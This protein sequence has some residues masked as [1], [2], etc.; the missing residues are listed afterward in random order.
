[1]HAPS[2]EDTIQLNNL[3]RSSYS[4]EGIG[5]QDL[6]R[7]KTVFGGS[8]TELEDDGIAEIEAAIRDFEL[9]E[10]QRKVD[11]DSSSMAQILGLNQRRQMNEKEQPV[12]S[13]DKRPV[14]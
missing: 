2:V 7:A 1:M 5:E 8:A 4:L 9:R 13:P 11:H 12:K 10:A 14:R 3:N 6:Q